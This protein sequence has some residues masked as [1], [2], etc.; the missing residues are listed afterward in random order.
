MSGLAN[1]LLPNEPTCI[2][3]CSASS[4]RF[5]LSETR[6]GAW[7]LLTEIRDDQAASRGAD[8]SSDKPGRSFDI[9]GEG[10]HAMS[11]KISG[12]EH[13][14]M[15]FAGEIADL[16]NNAIAESKV[17]SLVILAAPAVLGYLR[18]ALSDSALSA[19]SLSH[20]I[21]LANLEEA[22]IREYFE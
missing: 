21:N 11:Q 14:T 7:K 1:F 22:E 4:A 15:R 12:Q 16:L 9:V 10:R 19:V 17:T 3:A 6:F 20:S 13:Q 8:F 5:W 2:V 18:S